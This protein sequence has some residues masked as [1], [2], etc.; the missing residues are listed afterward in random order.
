MTELRDLK[1]SEINLRNS[2]ERERTHEFKADIRYAL[3]IVRV[4]RKRAE[5]ELGIGE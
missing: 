3:R 4:R 1:A 5:H 2:L